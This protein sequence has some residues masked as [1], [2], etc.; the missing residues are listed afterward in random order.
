MA[1]DCLGISNGL[2]P[3]V[4]LG[5]SRFTEVVYD[6]G[7]VYTSSDTVTAAPVLPFLEST[8]R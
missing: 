8:V 7:G 5:K 6:T 3:S 1:S 4:S 2:I